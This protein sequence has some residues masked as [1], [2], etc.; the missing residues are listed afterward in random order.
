MSRQH[1][2]KISRGEVSGND[3]S[4]MPNLKIFQPNVDENRKPLAAVDKPETEDTAEEV[5]W[6]LSNCSVQ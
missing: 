6:G 3:T 1:E 4:L 5:S 2:A